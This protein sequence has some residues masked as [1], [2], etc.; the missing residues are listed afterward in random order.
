[1]NNINFDDGLQRFTINN[2]SEKV[3]TFNPAD[4]GMLDRIVKGVKNIEE[5]A[6]SIDEL[7]QEKRKKLEQLNPEKNKEEISVAWETA[8][9][10][11][12]IT[13]NVDKVIKEQIDYIF[14]SPVSD[15]VF[16][17]TSPMAPVKG[18]PFY[19]RFIEAVIPEIEKACN[20]ER[21]SSEKRIS[22]YRLG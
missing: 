1:M 8:E 11:A 13:S 2:D 16:G 3:I 15:I 12:D 17:T 7:S 14:G 6:K 10:M 19:E 4:L 5:A 9:E 21:E 22:K 18:V 20:A